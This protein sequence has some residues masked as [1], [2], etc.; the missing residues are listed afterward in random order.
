MTQIKLTNKW[1]A[2]RAIINT[3]LKDQTLYCNNCQTDAKYFLA[4]ESCCENPQIGRNVDHMMGGIKQNKMIR[5]T[6]LNEYG[7]TEDK[8]IRFSVSM[9]PRLLVALE[10][11]FGK[12][13]EKVFNDQKELHAF[14][15]QFPALCSCKVI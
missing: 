10:D 2:A 8:T 7:S 9:P 13:N 1:D 11:Y 6:A 12:H 4:S 5:E 14:M 3:W 15:K